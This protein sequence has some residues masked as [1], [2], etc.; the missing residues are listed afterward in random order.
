MEFLLLLALL[1]IIRALIARSRDPGQSF[2]F[3]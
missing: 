3:W 1:G 2:I